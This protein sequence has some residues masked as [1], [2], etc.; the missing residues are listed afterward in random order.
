MRIP[1]PVFVIINPAMRLLLRSP[2]H[3]LMS[4]SL[5]LI[6]FVGRKSG[7]TF[8]TPVRYMRHDDAIRCFTA[9]SSKWWRNMRGGAEVKLLIRGQ[10]GRYRAVAVESPPEQIRAALL[11]LFEKFPQDA[12]YYNVDIGRDGRPK[13]EDMDLAAERTVLV[14]A[15]RLD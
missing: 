2:L 6:T 13:S 8:T 12:P 7:R 3:W 10:E 14:E 1:E 4:D 5:M 15:H 9:A 11:L